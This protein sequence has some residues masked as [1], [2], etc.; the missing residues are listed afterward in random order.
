MIQ[1]TIHNLINVLIDPK[2]GNPLINAIDFQIGFFKNNGEPYFKAPHRI[3]IK[4]YE[5]FI[6]EPATPYQIFH[7]VRGIQRVCIHDYDEGIAIEKHPKGF[8]IY[9]SSPNFLINLFIQLILIDNDYS[10][11]HAAVVADQDNRITLLPAAGGVGKTALLGCL[12]KEHGFKHMGDDI[13]ILGKNGN[14]LAF[15]RYFVFKEY[16]RSVYPEVFERLNIKKKSY[17][18][19]KRFIVDNAPFMGITKKILR[20]RK[21]YHTVAHTVNLTPY[22]ATI[23]V[24]EIFGPEAYIH[25]GEIEKIVFLERYDGQEFNSVKISEAS[26]SSRM[27]SIIH[28]E[29]VA[30]MQQLFMAGA[31][32]LIDLPFY[33]QKTN[34]IIQSGIYRKSC[35]LMLIPDNASP[36]DV[37]NSFI[38]LPRNI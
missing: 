8:N 32:E 31:M 25:Q 21:M 1:Y 36:K 22:L 15:P 29:W 20:R 16:H 24:D 28:H 38:A 7:N 4:P 26:I 18:G 12:V 37:V 17:Y 5:E 3:I 35:L 6:P 14:C 11:V 9:S 10:M 13:V 23:P 27:F 2:V 34:E 30:Y 33:F 19:I